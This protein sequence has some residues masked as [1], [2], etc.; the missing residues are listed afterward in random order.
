MNQMRIHKNAEE[1]LPAIRSGWSGAGEVGLKWIVVLVLSF[2]STP[3]PAAT[4]SATTGDVTVDTRSEN[5]SLSSLSL[6]SAGLSPAFSG[7]ITSYTGGVPYGIS[8]T[9]VTAIPS[10]SN[11]SLEYRINQGD[12]NSLTSGAPSALLSL[13]TG[14]NLIE[15]RVT[16]QKPA[17]EKTYS[18]TVD[19]AKAAQ[20]ISFP[21]P[22]DH[23][24]NEEVILSA[25]GGGSGNPVVFSVSSGPAVINGNQLV[26]TGPG[27]VKV[28]AS[29]AGGADHNAANSVERTFEVLRPLPDVA[30]GATSAS[31]VGTGIHSPAMQQASLLSSKARPV[32]G[33]FSVANRALLPGRRAAD[34]IEVQGSPGSGY[35][36]V[37]YFGPEGNISAEVL[38]NAYQTPEIDESDDP[39]LIRMV[40]T[41]EKK[42]LLKKKGKR[43][44][45]LRKSQRFSVRATSSIHAP[46]SDEAAI[47]VGTK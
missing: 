21:S 22:G 39:V 23:F 31:M 43:I 16:A 3:S 9:T 10:E 37:A 25:S 5:A 13:Q 29:Q 46:S 26:F 19:R 30:A 41:P 28:V 15:I 17:F 33:Y 1:L 40:V 27:T 34:R 45:T 44:V 8:T 32:T 6:S 47:V 7:A 35:F 24:F 36:R 18:I 4:G 12:Y 2:A 14:S 42:K 38:G 20:I 11:A